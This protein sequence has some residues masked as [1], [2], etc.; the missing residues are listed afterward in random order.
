[1]KYRKQAQCVYYT[2]Y[3]IIFVTKYRRKALKAG[4][5]AFCVGIFRRICKNYPDLVLYEANTDEDHIHF[6]ISIPPKWEI[7]KAIN[8]LKSNSAKAMREKFPFLQMLYDR[9][10]G[11]WSDGYF[12]STVG[13]DEYTIRN[14]IQHQ[15][16]EDSAQAKL[17]L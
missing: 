8:I 6:L 11:F 10:V 1:M 4:M 2:R 3:H 15:G 5:G 16:E 14:Y 7:S 12:L 9:H 13:I 17:E